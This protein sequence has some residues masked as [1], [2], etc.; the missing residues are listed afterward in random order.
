MFFYVTLFYKCEDSIFLDALPILW[1]NILSAWFTD[2]DKQAYN[3]PENIQYTT[4]P[5]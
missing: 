3:L 4:K 2:A 1:G 5:A